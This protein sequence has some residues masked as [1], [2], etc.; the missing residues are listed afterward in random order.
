MDGLPQGVGFGTS[1]VMGG[2]NDPKHPWNGVLQ[3]TNADDCPT[4]GAR[5][6]RAFWPIQW[7]PVQGE[8]TNYRVASMT[9]ENE[10]TAEYRWDHETHRWVAPETV[11]VFTFA[12]ER[13]VIE[14]GRPAT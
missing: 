2:T 9:C 14:T 5:P 10:H 6:A 8:P 7:P 4:C 13:E 11:E 12:G 1:I 3:P